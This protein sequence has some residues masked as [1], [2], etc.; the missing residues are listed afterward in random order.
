MTKYLL[1]TLM[2]LTVGAAPLVAVEDEPS[3][4]N[5]ESFGS[6]IDVFR[7]FQRH[8]SK[9]RL[10]EAREQSCPVAFPAATL[11]PEAFSAN[12]GKWKPAKVDGT[13]VLHGSYGHGET[14]A[15]AALHIDEPGFYRVWVK[16]YRLEGHLASFTLRI[17]PPE[18][19]NQTDPSVVSA[20]G[21]Y[22]SCRFDW[23]EHSP[24]RPE[25]LPDLK[26]MP[27]GFMWES[28]P[29]VELAPG[30]YTLELATMIHGG[31]Y[32]FR[33]VAMVVLTADPL[34]EG[35]DE[36]AGNSSYPASDPIRQSWN[37]WSQRPG[38]LPWESL[39][40]KQ[41]QYYLDWRTS[42]LKKIAEQPENDA[43]KRLAAYSYFDEEVNLIGT[44][45]DVAA[46]KKRL[47]SELKNDYSKSFGKEIEAEEMRPVKGW[48][49]KELTD[50]S[51]KILQAGYGD[52][53]ASAV[54][55]L[56]L[57]HAGKYYV[58]VRYFMFHKYY[59]LFDLA[60]TDAQD[61]AIATLNYGQPEDR[62]QRTNNQ[63][64][65]ECLPVELPAG[66]LE[67]SLNKNI[68][69]GPY[70]Y[71]RV[72]KIFITDSEAAL[73]QTFRRAVSQQPTTLW[74][75]Q[76][77]W[78][79]FSRISAP[80]AEDTVEP[81]KIVLQIPRG[82]TAS[83]LL[84]LRNETDTPVKPVLQLSGKGAPQLRLVAYMNTALY[85]WTPTI[86]LERSEIIVPPQQNASLWLTFST[87]SLKQGKYVPTLSLGER[88][89]EFDVMVTPPDNKRSTPVV[90][91]WCRPFNR[92]SCWKLF[93]DIG[94]NLINGV[95]VSKEEMEKYGLRHFYIS[96]NDYEPQAL[97]A[98]LGKLRKL[99]LTEND[100]SAFLIDEPTAKTVDRWLELAQ[101]L[102]AA[103]PEVQIWCNPGEVQSSTPDIIRKMRPYI[104]VFCPY[105]N[106]FSS[107][108]EKYRSEE[109]PA[110]GKL[111][112]LYT[113]P[114]FREK[115]PGS[116]SEL[117]YLGEM[118][119]K[120]NRDGWAPFSLFCSYPYSNSIWDEMHP[121]NDCQSV[122]FYPGAY[123]RTLS[124]RNMEAM[125]E[126]IQRYRK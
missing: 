126:A 14:S 36:V 86:L 31:P 118:A 115:S 58:W 61:K 114:C 46:E 119:A 91:G 1:A 44:P 25:R 100:W 83:V 8:W 49:V 104:D 35:L 24:M 116:P 93:H 82:D 47:A 77:P 105:L 23:S 19:L 20:K 65:W 76:N 107:K 32:T 45:A 113:T 38:S 22:Y 16:Y 75:Q 6:S 117:L 17:L 54:S 123:G 111:K 125:R 40:L 96:L 95:V 66:Q 108:D 124:T 13:E 78:G 87:A 79:A 2:L 72:D 122:S 29:M 64:T 52:G 112:L 73:P 62:L 59:S 57:P 55:P 101:K 39:T 109:L 74:Q 7:D 97:K 15:R 68:G 12:P 69:K 26:H 41:R 48:E 110:I 89:I 71:R 85:S 70:T 43:E 34:L 5:W 3:E 42:F 63:L 88:K 84:H 30:D 120:Y 10:P 21:E 67:L 4:L 80:L 9:N 11:R 51:N 103:T 90:G 33:K 102:R 27:T 60:F 37:A 28:G 18:L 56:M 99:G 106:H 53:P 121:F 98:H 50:A 92:E 81:E 94:L